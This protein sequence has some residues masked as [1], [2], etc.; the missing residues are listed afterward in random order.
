MKRLS[1][2]SKKK[3]IGFSFITPWVL[4]F[5]FLYLMPLVES[6]VYSFHFLQVEET[7]FKMTYVGIQNYK[8]AF[9]SDPDFFKSLVQSVQNLVYQV[10][11]ILVFSLIIALVLNQKFR[12]RLVA[13]AIFF[14]PVIIAS[15]IVIH[16]LNGDTASALIKAGEKSSNIFKVAMFTQTL[17]EVGMP[18]EMVSL[19]TTTV[20]SIF[21]LSWR[22][23]VQIL[24]FLAGLQSVSVSLYEA[25]DMDGCT[26]WERFW[27]ITFPI[28]SPVIL[29]NMVYTITDSFITYTNSTMVLILDNGRK[30][31]FA[32]SATL[33]WIYFLVIIVILAIA[34]FAV[35]RRVAYLDT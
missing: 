10:P 9:L 22:S 18:A 28:L 5:F 30:M 13:R 29:V 14:V 21:E 20:N 19:I 25:A 32:Y 6:L 17:Q 15:G 4:G 16:I 11:M 3:W 33:A 26:A 2:E 35:N 8:D 34:Y 23:G 7:G 24:L 1:I 12:G 27:K 31:E